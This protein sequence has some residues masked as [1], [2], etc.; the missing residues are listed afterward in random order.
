MT[1]LLLLQGR[2]LQ[3]IQKETNWLL[4]SLAL[5]IKTYFQKVRRKKVGRQKTFPEYHMTDEIVFSCM[6]KRFFTFYFASAVSSRAQR[7]KTLKL[8]S[9]HH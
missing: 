7:I 4:S 9:H 5:S 8:E 1:A 3:M 2:W 6:L